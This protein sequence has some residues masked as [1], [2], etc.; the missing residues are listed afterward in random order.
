MEYRQLQSRWRRWSHWPA[1][2]VAGVGVFVLVSWF[3]RSLPLAV[4]IGA[5]AGFLAHGETRRY[6]QRH[7]RRPRPGRPW[8]ARPAL[9]RRAIFVLGVAAVLTWYTIGNTTEGLSPEQA[10][11]IV[12]GWGAWGPVMLIGLSGLAML[13]APVPNGPFAIAAGVLWGP[14]FGT[15]Y[16]LLGQ[17]LGATLAFL[18]AR[19]LGR[20][21][22]PRLVGERG[23]YHIDQV[24]VTMGPH[25]VFWTRMAPFIPID[26]TAYAAGLTAMRY[27]VYILAFMGGAILPTWI[28]VWVGDT[29]H[30]SWSVRFLSFGV[31]ILVLIVITIFYIYRHPQA[32]PPRSQWLNW[33][34]WFERLT[35]SPAEL[36]A[37]EEESLQEEPV[38]PGQPR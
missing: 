34:S 24:S 16:A 9:R 3:S 21:F 15:I 23:A 17:L 1:G 22:L 33:N 13:V 28:I 26:F 37:Q 8:I 38:S 2:V 7:I 27:R 11:S 6:L 32:I 18:A 35:S 12:Q 20:R 29:L 36:P 31:V 10:R 5:L 4:A 30:Q 25:L 14:W 19:V